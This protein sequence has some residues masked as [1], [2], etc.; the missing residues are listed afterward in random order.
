MIEAWC[1]GCGRALRAAHQYVRR[2]VAYY[3]W[4]DQPVSHD[5]I[6]CQ[7]CDDSPERRLEATKR[8]ERV[9]RLVPSRVYW[10]P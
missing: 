2:Q 1:H 7:T 6:L 9:A 3:V 4:R 8:V 10:A 5:V